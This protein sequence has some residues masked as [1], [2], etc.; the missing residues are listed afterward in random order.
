MTG[1]RTNLWLIP[2]ALIGACW[3][4]WYGGGFGKAGLI[5]RF[6]KYIAL[7]LIVLAMY[8]VKGL[9]DWQDWRMYGSIISFMIFWAVAHGT[10]F[11]YWDHS[12]FAEGRLPLLDKF[13]WF[14]IGVEE[15]RTFWGNGFGMFCRYTLTSIPVAF[16][17]SWWFL[18]AGLIVSLCYAI[19][20]Y[21]KDTRIGE[22]LAGGLV[23]TL[24]FFCI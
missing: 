13:I 19:A 14:C 10:W 18:T 15:S 9:L 23:F 22:C 6:W 5:T 1:K 4:R 20:G 21:K 11:I 16:C 12:D 3:R 17:T 8:F 24:L 2:F 7:A